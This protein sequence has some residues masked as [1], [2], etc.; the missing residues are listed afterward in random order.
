MKKLLEILNDLHELNLDHSIIDET[1]QIRIALYKNNKYIEVDITIDEDSNALIIKG[2]EEN[3]LDYT[4]ARIYAATYNIEVKQKVIKLR[5]ST[6]RLI[7][8]TNLL[9]NNNV[10]FSVSYIGKE[11]I[12]EHEQFDIEINHEHGS[13]VIKKYVDD[14]HD[15]KIAPF[16][17]RDL[18]ML[19]Q[20]NLI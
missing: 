10:K 3:Y 19:I 17:M 15:Q 14:D 13:M 5:K 12:I 2:T 18:N 1:E 4:R 11:I 7:Q 8:I 16:K 6:K 20:F 9:N